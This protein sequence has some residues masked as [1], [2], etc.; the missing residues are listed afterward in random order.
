MPGLHLC[1]VVFLWHFRFSSHRSL[2]G[3]I[4]AVFLSHYLFAYSTLSFP[5]SLCLCSNLGVSHLVVVASKSHFLGR[6]TLAEGCSAITCR[7]IRLSLTISWETGDSHG[8]PLWQLAPSQ[9]FTQ[10]A[11]KYRAFPQTCIMSPLHCDRKLWHLSTVLV[12]PKRKYYIFIYKKCITTYVL[13]MSALSSH[14]KTCEIITQWSD[15]IMHII[16]FHFC[17]FIIHHNIITPHIVVFSSFRKNPGF[18]F[19]AMETSLKSI[20]QF[21]EDLPFLMRLL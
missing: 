6:N 14:C 16:A 7:I 20:F 19:Y 13:K 17:I 10:R 8:Q 4:F 15:C 3:V 5:S 11:Q 9:T 2:S 18:V 21:K 1:S 12:F